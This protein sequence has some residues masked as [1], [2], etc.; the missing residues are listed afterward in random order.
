MSNSVY[1]I[2]FTRLLPAPLK[3]DS[4]MLALGVSISDTLQ[5]NIRLARLDIIYPRIDELDEFTLDTLARDF[6]VD[7]YDDTYPI[8][9][10][11]AIIKS[12]VRVHK[13]LGTKYAVVKAIGDI[14]PNSEVEE[15][16]EYGG[17]HHRF[18]I[19]LDLTNAKAPLNLPQIIKAAKFYKRLSAHLDEV[20]YQMSAVIEIH[21]GTTYYRYRI[22]RT[23]TYRTGTRPRR[24]TIGATSNTMID[25]VV[26]CTNGAHRF[27]QTGTKPYRSTIAEL[28]TVSITAQTEA[29]GYKD[30]SDF[31]GR[32]SAG[33]IPHRN[34]GGGI[35]QSNVEINPSGK[36]HKFINKQT[37]NI[38]ERSTIWTDA[39]ETVSIQTETKDYPFISEQSGNIP[40]RSTVLTDTNESILTEVTAETF[41]H[42]A[43]MAAKNNVGE[44]PYTNTVWESAAESVLMQ[45][46]TDNYLFLSE[47]SGNMPDRST[48]YT[49]LDNNVSTEITVE[50]FLYTA[51]MTAKSNAGENPYTNSEG[52]NNEGGITPTVTAEKFSFRVK[53]CGTSVAKNNKKG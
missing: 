2:D 22:A 44:K 52:E 46:E 10:K 7:W 21:T 38:P 17:T 5:E 41:L 47:Q 1:N 53:R 4:E 18:R 15:W 33:E 8:E 51:D 43:D 31:S 45:T 3:N 40:E 6:H 48:E 26:D 13:R 11:R 19:I 20:V 34:V 25:I 16:F 35:S 42:T 36:S 9:A 12:S 50:T 37:G 30:V 28:N 23:D 32:Y 49:T 14:F 29:Q 39:D 27:V 24:N